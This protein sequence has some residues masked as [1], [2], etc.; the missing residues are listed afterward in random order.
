MD[1]VLFADIPAVP[2]AYGGS[3]DHYVMYGQ[4]VHL[5]PAPIL[6]MMGGVTR[7]LGLGLRCP[8][9]CIRRSCWRA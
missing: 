4:E 3:N 7:H 8:P 5:D 2:T 6:A 9:A 1:M